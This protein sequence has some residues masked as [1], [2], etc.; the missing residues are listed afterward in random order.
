[1]SAFVGEQ[2]QRRGVHFTNLLKEKRLLHWTGFA[3]RDPGSHLNTRLFFTMCLVFFLAAEL[4]GTHGRLRPDHRQPQE[5]HI[6][7]WV[8]VLLHC[9]Y[10][11]VRCRTT[12]P[13]ECYRTL[14]V[15]HACETFISWSFHLLCS[16][17]STS[18]DQ[19]E[20]PRC[21]QK[22]QSPH[23]HRIECIESGNLVYAF[24][25]RVNA[26]VVTSLQISTRGWRAPSRSR[27][28]SRSAC[29]GTGATGAARRTRR[30][31][32]PSSGSSSSTR[33]NSASSR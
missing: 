13:A 24:K 28:S 9:L 25:S 17:T 26:F 11:P 16:H 7:K 8:G 1:M 33:S 31:A 2:V 15:Y 22:I 32:S 29:A 14:R 6:Q 21:M 10:T 20:C 12:V 30:A 23:L 18:L 3:S 27:T 5:S 4:R 19:I